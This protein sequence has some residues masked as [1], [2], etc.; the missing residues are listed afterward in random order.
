MDISV[1]SYDDFLASKYQHRSGM[2]AEGCALC[3]FLYDSPRTPRA[4]ITTRCQCSPL[5]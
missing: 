3:T 1:L 4:H 2:H 5:Q